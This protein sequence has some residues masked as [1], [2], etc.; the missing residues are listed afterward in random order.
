MLTAHDPWCA[1]LCCRTRG[2]DHFL[3]LTNGRGACLWPGEEEPAMANVIKV[4]HF[5]WHHTGSSMPPGWH[6]LPNKVSSSC[7]LGLRTVGG[8]PACRLSSHCTGVLVGFDCEG[9]AVVTLLLW[10]LSADE[11]QETCSLTAV[12]TSFTLATTVYG[13]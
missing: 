12:C 11:V 8:A 7:G 2:L 13:L 1:V 10:H 9:G 5:G 6:P 4:V 3:W